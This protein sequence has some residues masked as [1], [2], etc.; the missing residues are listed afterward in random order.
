MQAPAKPRGGGIFALLLQICRPYGA[1]PA[2]YDECYKYAVPTGLLKHALKK[3]LKNPL[4]IRNP[5]SEIII[6]STPS[7][8]D[9]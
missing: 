1:W 2:R 6:I 9:T 3:G 7:P 5:C 8:S 4:L